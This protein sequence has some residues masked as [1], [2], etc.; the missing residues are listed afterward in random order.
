MRQPAAASAFGAGRGDRWQADL[1]A[2]ARLRLAAAGVDRVHGG[3]LC[4]YADAVRFYSFR[5]ERDG[6]RMAALIWRD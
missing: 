2:L 6:G 3:G 5:R 4:T 1:Y